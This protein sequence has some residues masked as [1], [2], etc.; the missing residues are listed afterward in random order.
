MIDNVS[1]E[2]LKKELQKLREQQ[3]VPFSCIFVDRWNDEFYLE[4]LF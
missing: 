4:I 1:R 3:E 2:T